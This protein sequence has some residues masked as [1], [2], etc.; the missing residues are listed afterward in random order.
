LTTV[1][2]WSPMVSEPD[3]APG[4]PAAISDSTCPRLGLDRR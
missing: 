4:E 1:M 2:V 3:Q